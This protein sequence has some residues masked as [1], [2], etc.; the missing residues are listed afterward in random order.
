MITYSH[1]GKGHVIVSRGS[2]KVGMATLILWFLKEGEDRPQY[3]E[4][5]PNT[6]ECYRYPDWITSDILMDLWVASG[7][8]LEGTLAGVIIEKEEK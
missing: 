2:R 4:L 1:E 5:D 3:V 7:R 8:S 6:G